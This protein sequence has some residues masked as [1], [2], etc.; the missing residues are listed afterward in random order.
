MFTR[1]YDLGERTG[2]YCCTQCGKSVTFREKAELT[3]GRE[4][5]PGRPRPT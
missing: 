1:E 3:A 5:R 2:N 4:A